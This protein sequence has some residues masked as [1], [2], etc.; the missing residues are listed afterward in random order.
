MAAEN[1]QGVVQEE[2]EEQT[3]QSSWER[4]L[5]AILGALLVVAVAVALWLYF[6]SRDPGTNSAEAGFARDMT[7][8][9]SQAVEMSLI[10]RDRTNDEDLR[11]VATDILLTQQ[12]QLGQ[13]EAWLTLWDLPMTGEEPAMAWMDHPVEGRMPGLASPE[14][15]EQ[16][17]SL[18]PDEMNVLYL[19]LMI[20][21]HQAGIDMAEAILDRTDDPEVR[22]IAEPMV[23][24]Q[25]SEISLMNQMLE[26]LGGSAAPGA[27]GTPE[28]T[29]ATEHEDHG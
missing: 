4:M 27:S 2:N 14:E 9:H 7:V 3:P 22:R 26:R 12:N 24:M 21:H 6:D 8:H 16:L 25:Q 23:K 28:A 5:I 29:P 10:A 1:V 20:T 18:P 17:K 19:R 11:F 15:I 13:M